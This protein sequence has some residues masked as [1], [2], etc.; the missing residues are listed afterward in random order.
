MT[1][2][3]EINHFKTLDI[4]CQISSQQRYIKFSLLLAESERLSLPSILS[5]CEY[6]QQQK[7]R[8]VIKIKI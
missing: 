5:S 3:K 2:H 4:Y 6:F 7:L 1:G 8:K